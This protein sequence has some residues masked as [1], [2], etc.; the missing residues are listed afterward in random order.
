MAFSPIKVQTQ[1]VSTPDF[2]LKKG[3]IW[4]G[5]D[6]TR[7][8]GPTSVSGFYNGYVCPNGGYV[9]YL[10]KGTGD[11]SIYVC[12]DDNALIANTKQVFG[13]PSNPST[14]AEALQYY[15][16]NNDRACVN[17]DYTSLNS[18]KCVLAL[19]AGF[20]SSYPRTGQEIKNFSETTPPDCG[21][22]GSA[23]NFSIDGTNGE[24]SYIRLQQVSGQDDVVVINNP[25]PFKTISLWFIMD[26]AL[27][28]AWTLLETDVANSALTN[29]GIGSAFAQWKIFTD[30]APGFVSLS[31]PN[32]YT[33]NDTNLHNVILTSTNLMSP[34]N[35]MTLFNLIS[36]NKG[37]P[38]RFFA[39]FC[40]ADEF[41]N[42][43]AS[44]HQGQ[45][46]NRLN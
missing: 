39:A 2:G 7:T 17:F 37:V 30:I 18:N 15:L 10:N 21:V 35:V 4:F 36:Q 42:D 23:T 22:P 44:D 25:E 27:P 3:V 46:F 28:G 19:D 16:G 34:T 31:A 26:V 20:V 6:E 32:Q 13:L 45:F 11:P 1:P 5:V 33:L 38:V 41:T 8:Y 29:S 24:K 9:T 12:A 40:W 43:M 14:V